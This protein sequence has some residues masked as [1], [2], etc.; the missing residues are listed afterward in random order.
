M[1]KPSSFFFSGKTKRFAKFCDQ[2]KK[3]FNV[4]GD[5]PS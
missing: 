4:A 3:I 1:H 2:A 5:V